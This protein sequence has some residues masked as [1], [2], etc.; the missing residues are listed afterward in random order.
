[1]YFVIQL[2]KKNTK[3]KVE[4]QQKK[5]PALALDPP[6]SSSD[7]TDSYV[8]EGKCTFH[9]CDVFVPTSYLKMNELTVNHSG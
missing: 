6:T 9:A 5:S 7:S 3:I 8:I 1:M 2:E 4:K